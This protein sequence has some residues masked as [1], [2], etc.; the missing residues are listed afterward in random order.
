LLG[1]GLLG[2]GMYLLR[3]YYQLQLPLTEKAG[4]LFVGGALLL[5][6]RWA[7]LRI[8]HGRTA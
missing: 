2:I 6:A 4:W 1:L 7:V 3:Y 5:A 8:A